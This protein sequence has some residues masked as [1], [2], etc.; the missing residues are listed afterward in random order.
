MIYYDLERQNSEVDMEFNKA[1]DR[2]Q[3]FLDGFPGRRER[4]LLNIRKSCAPRDVDNL[5]FTS[6]T[7]KK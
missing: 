3:M 6:K 2:T 1:G 5:S 4:S 7:M